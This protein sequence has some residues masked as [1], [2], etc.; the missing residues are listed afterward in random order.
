MEFTIGQ[1]LSTEKIHLQT[2]LLMDDNN[3]DFA[4]IEKTVTRAHLDEE[5]PHLLLFKSHGE[6]GDQDDLDELLSQFQSELEH[7]SHTTNHQ[8]PK[9]FA[10]YNHGD[11]QEIYQEYYRP[12]LLKNN[13]QC[14]ENIASHLDHMRQ[15]WSIDRHSFVEKL[16]H[17]LR[18]NLGTRELR[19]I[20]NDVTE[21]QNEKE[22][23]RLVVSS[24]VGQAHGQFQLEQPFDIKLLEEY[25]DQCTHQLQIIE[26]DEGK[27]EMLLSLKI[28]HSPILIM[29]RT[30]HL[31]L[32]Q[33]SLLKGLLD[34]LAQAKNP[35]K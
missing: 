25:K 17:L 18:K 24:F 21:K 27:G 6:N 9:D 5:G 26:Y 10:N 15:L 34:G 16:W 1:I 19:I 8:R 2:F 7:Y 12:W 11:A 28:H 29:A 33:Q 35:S 3:E 30:F 23:D 13:L 22:K 32:F 20:F 31:D 14:L 4:L